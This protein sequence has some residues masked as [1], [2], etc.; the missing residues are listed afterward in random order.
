M[1]RT[2][3]LLLASIAA[4][5][6]WAGMPN[7]DCDHPFVYDARVNVIVLPYRN[8]NVNNADLERASGQLTLLL[9]QTI[10]FSALKYPSI[11]TVRMVPATPSRAAD[12]AAGPV[13]Q[14]LLGQAPG[15]ER[16]LGPDGAAILLWGQI[17]K[18]RDQVYLCSYARLLQRG[19][20]VA[21]RAPIAGKGEF[22]AKLPADSVTFPTRLIT[23]SA[24]AQIGSA[25][26]EAA[27]L[28]RDRSLNSP[29]SPLPM[30]PDVPFA[31]QV[32]EATPDGWMRI[33]GAHGGPSGWIYTTDALRKQSL[34]PRLPELR[35]VDGAIGYLESLKAPGAASI[36]SRAR[37]SLE[38]FNEIGGSPE[39]GLATA[40][41]KSML[42]VMFERDPETRSRGYQLAREA[43]ALAPYNADAR[44]LELVY[45]VRMGGPQMYQGADWRSIADEFAQAAA[46]GSGKK[47]I[48]DNLDLFYG[49]VLTLPG[50]V[51]EATVSEIR[52]RRD[53]VALLRAP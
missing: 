10:L 50:L 38:A 41:A 42:A 14:K 28:H 23:T 52:K 19:G 39:T 35:F 13:A 40:T 1:N 33:Q 30:D 15:A 29:G 21:L 18:E 22:V 6:L 9:Q 7:S 53:Q 17:Y 27:T 5:P 45:R 36:R 25:F 37:P 43:V 31:Y 11:G 12:C 47:Y 34:A 44:N 4:L 24:L 3:C 49:Q 16:Q 2:I 48:L 20:D 46:L 8:K 26:R 51:N 32:M